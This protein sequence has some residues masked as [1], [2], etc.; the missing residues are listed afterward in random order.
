LPETRTTGV[1]PT[2]AQVLALGTANTA[3]AA[4]AGFARETVLR[5]HRS[6]IARHHAA[7]SHPR[8]RGRPRP[9]RSIRALLL[10]LA[11]EN[12]S[13]GYRRIHGELL[14]LGVKV[15]PSTVWEILRDAGIDDEPQVRLVQRPFGH[16]AVPLD[17]LE[18]TAPL[19]GDSPP[20]RRELLRGEQTGLDPLGQIDLLL[21]AEQPD[22]ADRPE[23]HPEGIGIDRIERLYVLVGSAAEQF[24]V[25]FVGVLP[26]HLV[27]AGLVETFVV[28]LGTPGYDRAKGALARSHLAAGTPPVR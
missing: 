9:A 20:R 14:V 15:A 12:S 18:V 10:R 23:V 8:R 16:L 21:R 22:L 17:G 6:L 28:L 2:G 1:C 5:W 27:P 25:L 19:R 7:I 11:R 26:A 13:W 4:P 3:R 24:R